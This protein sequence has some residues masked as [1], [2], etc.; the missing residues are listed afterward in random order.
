MMSE[1]EGYLKKTV[2]VSM[3]D[4]GVV[5]AGYSSCYLMYFGGLLRYLGFLLCCIRYN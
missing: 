1:V 2:S 4:P 3:H 5:D